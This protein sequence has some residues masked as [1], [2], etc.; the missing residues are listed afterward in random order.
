MKRSNVGNTPSVVLRRNVLPVSFAV[1]DVVSQILN[2]I[3]PRVAEKE[4]RKEGGPL[5][6]SRRD[7]LSQSPHQFVSHF[8]ARH[9]LDG[10]ST[11]IGRRSSRS[12]PDRKFRS[13]AA[14]GASEVRA[15]EER[16]VLFSSGR[17][18][19]TDDDE[20]EPRR[21]RVLLANQF[22]NSRPSPRMSVRRGRGTLSCFRGA[23]L[24]FYLTFVM[25]L[26]TGS[27]IEIDISRL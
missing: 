11:C 14:P 1:Y 20:S 5:S 17:S 4:K 13:A 25:P 26:P 6:S 7:Y 19:A 22:L 3:I 16:R 18:L 23:P 8:R 9:P 15:G 10:I 27:Y 24:V 21:Y 12:L 2:S